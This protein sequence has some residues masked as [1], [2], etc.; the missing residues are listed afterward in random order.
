[1]SNN[2]PARGFTLIELMTVV[3]VV[4]VLAAIA[5]PVYQTYVARTQTTAALAE[6]TPGRTAYELLVDNGIVENDAYTDV[7]NLGLPSV[8]PRCKITANAPTDGQGTIECA[9]TGGTIVNGHVIRLSRDTHGAWTCQSDLQA[10]Y[11]PNGCV[12]Q[13]GP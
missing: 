5:I 2:R 6:I 7:D 3:A 10:R 11:L 9:M 12:V 13:P 8:T 1:M 4:A